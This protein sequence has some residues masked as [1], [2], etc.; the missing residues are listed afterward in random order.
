M[1]KKLAGFSLREIVEMVTM[2]EKTGVL[3]VE[4]SEFGRGRIWMKEG[5]ISAAEGLVVKGRQDGKKSRD[6]IADEIKLA[7]LEIQEWEESVFSF[8]AQEITK[9]E[10]NF[11]FDTNQV[12][13]DLDRFAEE[14]KRI[15]SEIPSLKATVEL[16]SDPEKDKIEL[17]KAQWALVAETRKCTTVEDYVARLKLN[18]FQVC[19]MLFELSQAGLVRCLGEVI[20]TNPDLTTVKTKPNIAAMKK[21]YIRKTLAE[22]DEENELVPAEW[23]SYYQLLDSRNSSAKRAASG[24]S[25][26]H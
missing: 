19:R 8:E 9:A 15:R 20:E 1:S 22:H 6:E 5:Q 17:T 24:A 12:I 26:K 18:P 23:A 16:I 21:K 2:K 3:T 10:S 4:S 14:W 11:L 13:S 25:Q 7:L